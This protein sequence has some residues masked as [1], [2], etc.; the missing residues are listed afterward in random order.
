MAFCILKHREASGVVEGHV[1]G[2]GAI[3]MAAANNIVSVGMGAAAKG[4]ALGLICARITQWASASGVVSGE[5]RVEV[6]VE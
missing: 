5:E 6:F 1:D 2:V 4:M 3:A